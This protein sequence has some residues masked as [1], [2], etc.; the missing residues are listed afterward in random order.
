[1][2]TMSNLEIADAL[3]D[4]VQLDVNAAKA[5]SQ[6]IEN[7]DVI[8]L[9]QQFAKFRDIHNQQAASLDKVIKALDVVPP[10]R[11]QDFRGFLM[12]SWTAIRGGSGIEGAL[13][14]MKTNAEYVDKKYREACALPLTPS[15]RALVEHSYRNV[16]AQLEFIEKALTNRIW[17]KR[18]A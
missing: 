5:Y 1:M 6:A 10:E 12:E 16:H 9:R 14:A 4:L 13:K 17:E 11:S 18:V 2:N 3:S 8:S 15:I 7:I